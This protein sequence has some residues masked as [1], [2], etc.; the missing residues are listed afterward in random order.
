MGGEIPKQ[1]MPLAGRELLLRSVDAFERHPGIEKLLLVCPE[2]WLERT[3]ALLAGEGFTKVCGVIR[4]GR[5]RRESSYLGLSWLSER[6]S[7]EDTVLIH[8][9]ARPLVSGAVLSACIGGARRFS[10]CTAAVPVQDTI[11]DSADGENAGYTLDRSRLFSV[12]TPQA[13]RLGVILSAH[14]RC[15]E[16]A[17]VT[18]D[19]GILLS[20]GT[21]VRLVPGEKRNLKIT[22]PEDMA[23]AEWL[24]KD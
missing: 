4:G 24:L 6:F 7:P 16:D 9:A 13:F 21:A 18:D 3:E 20:Q 8:D 10:A 11:L 19:A 15:P 2:A 12:Q 14:K 23:F 22:S 1:F 5:T 17:R